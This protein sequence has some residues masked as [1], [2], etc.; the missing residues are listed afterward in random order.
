VPAA[1]PPDGFFSA[2]APVPHGGANSSARDRRVHS[3]AHEAVPVGGHVHAVSDSARS[4]HNGV[5]FSDHKTRMDARLLQL[6]QRTMPNTAAVAAIKFPYDVSMKVCLMSPQS[7]ALLLCA[8]HALLSLLAPPQ[9]FSFPASQT[10]AVISSNS[11]FKWAENCSMSARA[12]SPRARLCLTRA[13]TRVRSVGV[14]RAMRQ[15]PRDAGPCHHVS[16][17]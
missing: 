16:G 11:S 6:Q 13:Q 14:H 5:I 2:M 17:G 8:V 7:I 4:A 1:P 9:W 3:R 15:R 10:S 12:C